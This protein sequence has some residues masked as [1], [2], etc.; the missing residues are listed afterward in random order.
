[1]LVAVLGWYLAHTQVVVAHP[2]VDVVP[3]LSPLAL[4]LG[5]IGT[6]PAFA[7]PVPASAPVR[8]EAIV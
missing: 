4:V 6:L 1:V 5:V 8:R 7:T 3:Y 2:G